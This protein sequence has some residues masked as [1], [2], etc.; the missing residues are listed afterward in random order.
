M[1]R[2][3]EIMALLKKMGIPF[4]HMS[5]QEVRARCKSK[6]LGDVEVRFATPRGMVWTFVGTHFDLPDLPEAKLFELFYKLLCQ[7]W[8]R[9]GVKFAINAKKKFLMVTADIADVDLM[10]EEL[11]YQLNQVVKAAEW[12]SAQLRAS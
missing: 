11:Q 6:V 5:D 12:L 4:E 7:N 1:S 2:I 9:F 3:L 8:T 10:K